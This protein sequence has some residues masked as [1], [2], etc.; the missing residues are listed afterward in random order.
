[1]WGVTLP[2]AIEPGST[3]V[4]RVVLTKFNPPAVT[5]GYDI[6]VEP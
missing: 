6:V 2:E 1:M 4:F 3:V 5:V